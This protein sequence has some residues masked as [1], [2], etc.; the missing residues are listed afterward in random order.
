MFECWVGM[1][2]GVEFTQGDGRFRGERTSRKRSCPPS[3]PS[4][5]MMEE[6][7]FTN[8]WQGDDVE[9]LRSKRRAGTSPKG[10]RSAL[11]R[12]RK[13]DPDRL[14]RRS[15]RGACLDL[16]LAM[17]STVRNLGGPEQEPWEP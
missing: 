11:G 3:K 16:G 15:I 7:G 10:R 6:G 17:Y 9:G 4:S 12:M 2:G 1:T 8:H 5:G 13:A 14:W